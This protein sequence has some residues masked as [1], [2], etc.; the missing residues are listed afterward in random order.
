M[1]K[2]MERLTNNLKY[3]ICLPILLEICPNH[4]T[5]LGRKLVN[6]NKPSKNYNPNFNSK[7]IILTHNY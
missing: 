2:E 5:S 3:P 6:K 7:T 4:R 1:T